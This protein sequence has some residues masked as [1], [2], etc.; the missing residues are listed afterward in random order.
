LIKPRLRECDLYLLSAS[1]RGFY[2]LTSIGVDQI[3]IQVA[4]LKDGAAV[5]TGILELSQSTSGYTEFVAPT[6]YFF[7]SIPNEAWLTIALYPHPD[8]TSMHAGSDFL[9]DDLAFSL[10]SSGG[11]GSCPIAATGDANEVGGINST[12]IIYLVNYVLKA[13]TEPL[14]GGRRRQL[15]GER[16]PDG[17]HVSCKLCSQEWSGAVRRVQFDTRHLVLPVV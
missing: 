5:G 8:S 12:D 9:I 7:D 6:T 2:D 4:M 15:F 1:L 10:D 11:G 3:F 14:P 16:E 13:G 17:C